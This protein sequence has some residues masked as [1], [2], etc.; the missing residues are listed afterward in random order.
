MYYSIIALIINVEIFIKMREDASL[1][2]I[3]NLMLNCNIFTNALAYRIMM[4]HQIYY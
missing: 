4:L 1:K 3:V 2:N